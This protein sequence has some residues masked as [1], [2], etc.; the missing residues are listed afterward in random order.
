MVPVGARNHTTEHISKGKM[1]IVMVFS[2]LTLYKFNK[3][4]TFL[5]V[6]PNSYMYTCMHTP[7]SGNMDHSATIVLSINT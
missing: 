5:E 4:R 3:F 6:N 2:I 7:I 1:I